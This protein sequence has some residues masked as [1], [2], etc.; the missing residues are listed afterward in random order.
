M[1][2]GLQTSSRK[3]NATSDCCERFLSPAPRTHT[4]TWPVSVKKTDLNIKTFTPDK[5]EC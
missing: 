2:E 1:Q 5:V 4:Y 3:Q